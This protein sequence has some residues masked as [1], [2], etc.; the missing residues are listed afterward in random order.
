MVELVVKLVIMF[1]LTFKTVV[2]LYCLKRLI[3]VP[4]QMCNMVLISIYESAIT[5]AI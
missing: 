3:L 5:R 4:Y 1:V 2:V